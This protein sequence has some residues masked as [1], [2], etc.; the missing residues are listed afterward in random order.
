MAT[1]RER[2]K[3]FFL[4]KT[5]D[6]SA[7]QVIFNWKWIA[8][9]SKLS[10]KTVAVCIVIVYEAIDNESYNHW[11]ESKALPTIEK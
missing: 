10:M 8:E 3:T 9:R 5:D 7:K 2:N 11:K 6:Q 1:D 4:S